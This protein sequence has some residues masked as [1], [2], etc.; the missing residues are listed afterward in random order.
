MSILIKIIIGIAVFCLIYFI[1]III[2]AINLVFK[3]TKSERAYIKAQNKI[4]RKA[5]L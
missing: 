2:S 3:L 4:K 1:L 5:G